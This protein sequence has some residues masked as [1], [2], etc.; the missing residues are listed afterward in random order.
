MLKR[1]R[2]RTT[3][4]GLSNRNDVSVLEK[5]GAVDERRACRFLE[6]SA[7]ITTGRFPRPLTFAHT[8]LS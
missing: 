5:R 4:Y 3:R 8:S 1:R 7:M 6:T 2:Q